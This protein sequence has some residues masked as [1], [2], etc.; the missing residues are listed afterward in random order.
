LAAGKTAR[1]A[2]VWDND[3]TYN[4][5]ANKQPSADLD[6][7]VNGPD[8]HRQG[9]SGSWDNTQ[10]VAE[11]T[12]NA[13]GYYTVVANKYRCDKPVTRIALAEYQDP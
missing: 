2:L 10:E 13:S 12:P 9:Y 6:L 4:Y 7:I 11:F 1:V 3:P 5:V 8:G